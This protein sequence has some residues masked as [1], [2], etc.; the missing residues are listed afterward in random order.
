MWNFAHVLGGKPYRIDRIYE[1]LQSS[2]KYFNTIKMSPAVVHV[3]ICQFLWYLLIST[4]ILLVMRNEQHQTENAVFL[5]TRHSVLD[6][7]L[8]PFTPIP[9]YIYGQFIYSDSLLHIQLIHLMV[10]VPVS[11]SSFL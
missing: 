7:L 1:Y 2:E 11:L 9:C 5:L 4:F 3:Y 10:D 8:N 6:Q